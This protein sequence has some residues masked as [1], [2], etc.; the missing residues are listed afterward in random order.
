[1]TVTIARSGAEEL[2]LW[3]PSG[4]KNASARHEGR[5]LSAEQAACSH[6]GAFAP[7]KPVRPTLRHMLMMEVCGGGSAWSPSGVT[8][9]AD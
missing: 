9:L 6:W 8:A 4:T 2:A 7:A 5:I 3:P 1:M